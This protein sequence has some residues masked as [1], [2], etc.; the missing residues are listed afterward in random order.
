MNTII[1]LNKGQRIVVT[2][3]VFVLGCH[4]EQIN[5]NGNWNGRAWFALSKENLKE[6]EELIKA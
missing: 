2:K 4:L 1:E 5:K 6:L 3:G